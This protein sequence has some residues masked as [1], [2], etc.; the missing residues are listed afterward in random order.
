MQEV[1]FDGIAFTKA[2]VLAKEFGYTADY[3]GQL[4]RGGKVQARLVG[5]TWY[6]SRDSLESHRTGLYKLQREKSRISQE[7]QN[8]SN[9]IKIS[10][11]DVAAVPTRTMAKNFYEHATAANLRLQSSAFYL[12]DD[13]PLIPPLRQSVPVDL[14]EAEVLS[15]QSVT[16]K[17]VTMLPEALPEV[18]MRGVVPVR[19]VVADPIPE[20]SPEAKVSSASSPMLQTSTPAPKTPVAVAAPAVAPSSSRS[21]VRPSGTARHEPPRVKEVPIRPLEVVLSRPVAIS[22]VSAVVIVCLLLGVDIVHLFGGV[23]ESAWTLNFASVA[24]LLSPY[25]RW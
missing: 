24:N 15:V 9:N 4:C 17:E 14:A 23:G 8:E 22:F 10:R 18:Y 2:S 21:L 19:A 11:I 5:R 12:D 3:L 25:I 6:V 16:H 20:E 7:N 13:E 1:T